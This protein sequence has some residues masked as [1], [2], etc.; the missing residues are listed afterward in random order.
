MSQFVSSGG[1]DVGGQGT[2]V[3][4]PGDICLLEVVQ[5]ELL[6]LV[7]L[8][9]TDWFAG[10]KV[11]LFQNDVNPR[12]NTT[13]GN[14]VPCNFSGYDGLRLLYFFSPA[15]MGGIRAIRASQEYVWTYDG[16]PVT[17][18]V[19][20][21]YIVDLAGNLTVA[22]RFCDG[23]FAMDVPRRQFKLTPL[24]WLKNERREPTS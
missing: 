6:R 17:N 10:H 20:G 21:Y 19:Y 4:N 18:Y 5:P 3:R 13:I 23:P 15:F 12:L 24:F 8:I 1:V 7:T 16:G 22:E 14:I 2:F 11:G 9:T